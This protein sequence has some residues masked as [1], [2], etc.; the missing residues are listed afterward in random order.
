M[1]IKNYALNKRPKSKATARQRL[2][3][4]KSKFKVKV[5]REVEYTAAFN[6]KNNKKLKLITIIC[7]DEKTDKIK[8]LEK[9]LDYEKPLVE[10]GLNPGSQKMLFPSR[11]TE[12][13]LRIFREIFVDPKEKEFEKVKEKAKFEREQFEMKSYTFKTLK[14]EPIKPVAIKNVELNHSNMLNNSQHSLK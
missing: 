11:K 10:K 3:T 6:C 7:P 8:L 2:L 9:K 13:E 12:Q 14:R 1:I 4:A 5:E